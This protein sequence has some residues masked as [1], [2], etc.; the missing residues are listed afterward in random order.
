MK[1]IRKLF[2]NIFSRRK[3][4]EHFV[5]EGIDLKIIDTIYPIKKYK[6]RCIEDDLGG[7]YSAIYIDKKMIIQPILV[8]AQKIITYWFGMHS[9]P[10][11]AIVLGCAGC[12]IVRFLSFKYSHCKIIGVEYSNI[13]I[14]IAKKYFFIEQY[15]NFKLL[16]NDAFHFIK[17][18]NEICCDLIFVDLFSKN[19]IC[20]QVLDENF[21][22]SLYRICN[23]NALV[24]LN[25][26]GVSLQRIKTVIPH[27][28]IK[29]IISDKNMCLYLLLVK[30]NDIDLIEKYTYCLKQHF[31]IIA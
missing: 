14:E 5:S 2:N 24:V 29:I 17:N 12:S 9:N 27:K 3:V 7:W 1:Y 30:S 21:I 10:H 18:V 16:H 20:P 13:L 23:T 31:N 25:M 26:Y 4:I 19:E 11:N 28:F 6:T 22:I 8:N 15:S